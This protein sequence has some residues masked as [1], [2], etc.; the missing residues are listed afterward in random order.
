M[1]KTLQVWRSHDAQSWDSLSFAH[2]ATFMTSFHP[3]SKWV[4]EMQQHHQENWHT[5]DEQNP[6]KKPNCLASSWP[7]VLT[8]YFNKAWLFT[9]T[10]ADVY[11]KK[12]CHEI[13]K[14]LTSLVIRKSNC[15]LE[16]NSSVH[17]IPSTF[18]FPS[19]G[20]FPLS[21]IITG[22]LYTFSSKL[23]CFRE[24]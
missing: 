7:G 8:L 6:N 17:R 16:V 11:C 23:A 3:T 9:W 15:C 20:G 21:L 12:K 5:N 24:R 19:K 13:N 10:L 22:T 18:T 1:T 2:S 14:K 4:S